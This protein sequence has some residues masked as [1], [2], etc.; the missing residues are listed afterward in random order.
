M[1]ES[2]HV[3]IFGVATSFAWEI[4]ESL[5]R[6]DIIISSID[7]LGGAD[8]NLPNLVNEVCLNTPIILGP[9]SP[10]ARNKCAALAF[11]IGNL[12]LATIVDPTAVVAQSAELS[13]GVFV[14][15]SATIGS[16]SVIQCH[17]TINRS[18]SIGHDCKIEQFASIGPGAVLTG[19]VKIGFGAFVGAGAVILPKVQISQGAIIGAGAVVVNDVAPYEVV[20]GNPARFFKK[21]EQSIELQPCPWC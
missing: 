18:A 5:S 19:G 3:Q 7:N 9:A 17:A 21:H 4:V 6:L 12:K 1:V 11:E 2:N 20:V 16:N 10:A 13:H 8:R 15:A 14:N